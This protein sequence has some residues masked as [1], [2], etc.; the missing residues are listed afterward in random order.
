MDPQSFICGDEVVV[1]DLPHLNKYI[2]GKKGVIARWLG[3]DN[4]KYFI[5]INGYEF[6]IYA[7]EIE[8]INE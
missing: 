4:D 1:K 2:R 5:N 6:L 3:Y 7:N 8:I